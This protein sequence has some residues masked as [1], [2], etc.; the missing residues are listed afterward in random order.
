MFFFNNRA[1][2]CLTVL[3]LHLSSVPIYQA[4]VGP[5]AIFAETEYSVTSSELDPLNQY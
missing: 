3:F 4:K 1:R 2:L 5:C